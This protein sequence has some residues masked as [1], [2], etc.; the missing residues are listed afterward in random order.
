MKKKTIEEWQ[1]FINDLIDLFYEDNLDVEFV[2]NYVFD[3]VN[4]LKKKNYITYEDVEELKDFV[5]EIL[6]E[7]FF[8]RNIGN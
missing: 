5:E 4:S 6:H 2:H 7:K 8:L 3:T 1:K